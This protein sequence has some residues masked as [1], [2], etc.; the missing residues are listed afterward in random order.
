VSPNPAKFLQLQVPVLIS[1]Q[2]PAQV[3]FLVQFPVQLLPAFSTASPWLAVSS[4]LRCFSSVKF[5]LF[6]PFLFLKFAS[7]FNFHHHW[8]QLPSFPRLFSSESFY[9]LTN[10]SDCQL[11]ILTMTAPLP[12]FRPITNPQTV[13]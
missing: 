1:A 4:S 11:H 13:M 3:L 6:F 9:Q 7:V 12:T 10:L 5:R 2:F 8:H